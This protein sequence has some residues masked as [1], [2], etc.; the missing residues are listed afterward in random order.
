MSEFL[1][2]WEE[3]LEDVT[4]K[5]YS[6][7]NTNGIVNKTLVSTT[8]VQMIPQAFENTTNSNNQELDRKLQGKNETGEM[9]F[10][11]ENDYEKG[12][13]IFTYDGFNYRIDKKNP[14]KKLVPHYEY[15]AVLTKV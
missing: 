12:K 10:M 14:I 4:V 15:I 13:T 5:I 6:E 8:T 1:D 3:F 7:T 9:L 2:T 11:S